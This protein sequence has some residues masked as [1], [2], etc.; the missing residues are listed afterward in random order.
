MLEDL[1]KHP[2]Q[3]MLCS[4]V[5]K[6]L[7]HDLADVANTRY[8]GQGGK[9]GYGKGTALKP[10][11]MAVMPVGRHQAMVMAVQA[12]VMAATLTAMKMQ[13]M[14]TRC[15]LEFGGMRQVRPSQY[16]A[17]GPS[18]KQSVSCCLTAFTLVSTPGISRTEWLS[19][20]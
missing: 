1:V 19:A 9:H 6:D 10:G 16:S 12:M 3:V 14:V 7:F 15:F 17:E 5:S 18:F 20:E 4:E 11:R 2:S 8:F 13:M